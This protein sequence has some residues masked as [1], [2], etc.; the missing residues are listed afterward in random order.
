MGVWPKLFNKIDNVVDIIVQPEIAG[1][2]GDPAGIAPVGDVDV[3]V[4][5]HFL[6]GTTQQ[7]CKVPGQRRHDQEF[8]VIGPRYAA[9]E[10]LELGKWSAFDD[11][12]TDVDLLAVAH[13]CVQIEG[14]LRV[15]S[16]QVA[17]YAIGGGNT[18][19]AW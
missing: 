8:R 19:S 9:L 16:S 6:H 2:Q 17:E 7:G 13:R 12:F 15:A 18:A 11:G 10:M 3:M 5:Q 1:R 4:R 14:R